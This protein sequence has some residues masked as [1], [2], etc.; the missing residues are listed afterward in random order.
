MTTFN[1]LPVAVI[2]VTYHEP[3]LDYGEVDSVIFYNTITGGTIPTADGQPF[4]SIYEN[5][6][7]TSTKST[8]SIY[9]VY[10]SVFVACIIAFSLIRT[11]HMVFIFR[12]FFNYIQK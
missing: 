6:G 11:C 9:K 7:T 3:A 5:L 8:D 10:V 4:F 1:D 12:F 2:D